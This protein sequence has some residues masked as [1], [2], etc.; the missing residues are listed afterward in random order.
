MKRVAFLSFDW[1]Y[2]IVSEYYLGIQDVLQG[3]RDV[4]VVI[5][6]A[7]DRYHVSHQ[8]KQSSF[9]IF[10]LFD[11]ADYDGVLVQGNRTWPPEIRQQLVDRIT[12][13][14]KP[15]ISLNYDLAGAYSVGTDNYREEY[16]LVRR[17][18]RDTGCK[19]PAFVN[20]LRTSG[21]AQDRARAFRDACE[22]L[23]ISDS[24]FYQA[25][26][27]QEAG[28]ITAKK[29]LRTPDNLPDV[30][31]CCNDDLAIGVQETLQEA[32]IRVPED[33]LIAGFDN[34]EPSQKATPRITT[35]DRD[36]RGIAGTALEL[37]DRLMRGEQAD[38]RTYSPAR[39]IL[40]P[41]C[42]YEAS[43]EAGL[44]QVDALPERFFE[45]LANFHAFLLDTS[46]LYAI[47]EECEAF[48]GYL[49]CPNAFLS[50]NES[51]LHGDAP[52]YASTYAP[53]SHL[54]AH[55]HRTTGLRCDAEHVY[56]SF[57]TPKLLPD[58][59]PMNHTLYLVTPLRQND[60]C[61]G[62]IVTEGVP[63]A[64][65]FGF[66]AYY[67]TVLAS[68]IIAVRNGELLRKLRAEL[69]ALRG[70]SEG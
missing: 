64:L 48:A 1:D 30:V 17:V 42:G 25:N 35:I 14:G 50:L 11:P 59:V 6:S 52:D 66:N 23:G 49:D 65:L 68:S 29:M 21:E 41:S 55:A 61:V 34:R 2:K 15:V 4:R 54:M 63:T 36:Y 57:D 3:L 5:Y 7:F 43:A 27:Q 16:E 33:I 12:A 69:A 10:S 56:A 9:E 39:H 51:F 53:T 70:T 13:Q 37:L 67:L 47:L 8:P 32:G 58:S 26:W 38:T 60:I 44:S 28:V 24:R 45:E 18:L 19:R 22:E 20:G 62:T 40:T 31:F 46:S